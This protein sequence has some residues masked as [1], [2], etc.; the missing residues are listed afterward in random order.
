MATTRTEEERYHVR[1]NV[2]RR[3]AG[4]N[5]SQLPIAT[6]I[7]K[8]KNISQDQVQR[9]LSE[10]HS[11]FA[12]SENSIFEA[13]PCWSGPQD[14]RGFHQLSSWGPAARS[15]PNPELYYEN[16]WTRYQTP[17]GSSGL[18]SLVLPSPSVMSSPDAWVLS[19][20]EMAEETHDVKEMPAEEP[21]EE[22]ERTS[23]RHTIP[24]YCYAPIADS[25]VRLLRLSPGEL[26]DPIVCALKPM[27]LADIKSSVLTFQALSYAWGDGP[28]DD[29]VILYDISSTSQVLGFEERRSN[30]LKDPGDCILPIRRNLF[31]ALRRIRDSRT[32][33]WLW[34]DAICID[35]DD[36]AEKD[37]QIP[38]MPDIYS[39][40][41]NVIA[42]L[43]EDAC[44]EDI[45]E[46]VT[47]FIPKI[48]DL[49]TRDA[50]LAFQADKKTIQSWLDL[51]QLL[52]SSW[53]SRR[54][55]I[56]EVAC[57]RKLSIRVRDRI[58]SWEDFVDSIEMY[59]HELD[60]IQASC[61]GTSA[62]PL[63]G[64]EC[65]RAMALIELSRSCFSKTRDLR[66]QTHLMDLETLVLTSSS[67]IVSEM[68]D[69][70]YALLYLAHDSKSA[71]SA[72]KIGI[73]GYG[74]LGSAY[75]RHPVDLF[76]CFVRYCLQSSTSLDIICRTWAT[77]PRSRKG[78]P[79]GKMPLPSWIGVASYGQDRSFRELAQ[80]Q[81]LLG[82]SGHSRYNAS[83]GITMKAA[84]LTGPSTYIL[85][86]RGIIIGLVQS[87]STTVSE[88]Y[89]RSDCLRILG[90]NDESKDSVHD[91]LWRSLAL[92]LT[93]ERTR[94]PS[95][96]RRAC[97]LALTKL[98][99]SG[100]LDIPRLLSG[101]VQASMLVDYLQ[102]VQTV[103]DGRKA[104]RCMPRTSRHSTSK[105][106][107]AMTEDH[108][109]LVGLG[110][111]DMEAADLL[112]IVFG[113]SVPV[114]LRRRS[115]DPE[116]MSS[117]SLVGPCYAHGCMEGE[118]FAG[119]TQEE[120][121]SMSTN[122]NLL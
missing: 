77:W 74:P 111:R 86:A 11:A 56:Q 47:K 16:E 10:I 66:I 99:I 84:I 26:E 117:M 3:R 32:Y 98:S 112:C 59:V 45:T 38:N 93:P 40:A 105:P 13:R 49:R 25:E 21:R 122:Y 110:P 115:K 103:T 42:W 44:G 46:R 78:Q 57:A 33:M 24:R 68:R 101:P 116:D 92:N 6:L 58:L 17:N 119:L 29:H 39:N 73:P 50:M 94:A 14:D 121:D 5:T 8:L 9:R 34:I 100:D 52:R 75:S 48:L 2:Y 113:C 23:T 69:T 41:F 88:G 22:K 19:Q 15:P 55:V 63:N 30:A 31:Q 80:S 108:R 36:N 71:V 104:F 67:F 102:R 76:V 91:R 54:W 79:Y 89:I 28:P 53:F 35:Q 7:E 37:Q 109:M 106:A 82:D 4:A 118:P 96:Y 62:L 72:L 1:H 107:F 83:R 97:N 12:W 20:S 60:H 90:C 120:I 18:S 87:T 43:G 61:D 114:V 65:A 95:W 51:G 70:I 27:S 85:R 64:P 81:V